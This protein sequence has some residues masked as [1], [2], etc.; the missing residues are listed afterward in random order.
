MPA[1]R[2]WTSPGL[3]RILRAE[4]PPPGPKCQAAAQV[5][6]PERG[7]SSRRPHSRADMLSTR[8]GRGPLL[9]AQCSARPRNARKS[10][11]ARTLENRDKLER[12][13]IETSSNARKSRQA[14]ETPRDEPWPP[15][16]APMRFAAGDDIRV[17]TESRPLSARRGL[18]THPHHPTS[19]PNLTPNLATHPRHPTSPPRSN[20]AFGRHKGSA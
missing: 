14:P 19:P 6:R 1:P 8:F 20:L 13:K 17:A 10:R 18:T 16:V 4:A 15:S 9:N 2:R 7:C 3:K 5:Y 11:Q 12:S